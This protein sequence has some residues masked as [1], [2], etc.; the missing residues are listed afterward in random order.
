[1]ENRNTLKGEDMYNGGVVLGAAST[2]AAAIVLPN[3]GDNMLL[4]VT[5]AVALVVGVGVLFS[6]IIRILA[7]RASKI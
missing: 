7:K 4:K 2:T 1:L 5:S 6:S 3:T